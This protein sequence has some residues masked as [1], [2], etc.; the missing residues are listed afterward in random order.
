M[1]VAIVLTFGQSAL[2]GI[3]SNTPVRSS[4]SSSGPA[5]GASDGYGLGRR[6]A[7]PDRQ[8]TTTAAGALRVIVWEG[9]IRMSDYAPPPVTCADRERSDWWTWIERTKELIGP[10]LLTA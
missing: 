4:Q 10:G 9:S 1:T 7:A 2:F 5:G 3:T 6:A 8:C